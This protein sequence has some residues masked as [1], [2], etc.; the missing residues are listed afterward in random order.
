MWY[1]PRCN[2]KCAVSCIFVRNGYGD[3]LYW[4]LIIIDVTFVTDCFVEGF[5]ELSSFLFVVHIFRST[6]RNTIHVLKNRCYQLLRLHYIFYFYKLC[7]ISLNE[8]TVQTK[9]LKFIKNSKV[10]DSF[11]QKIP[12]EKMFGR[13]FILLNIIH[14]KTELPTKQNNTLGKI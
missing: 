6:N 3:Q 9:Q 13:K 2:S 7:K 11:G 14:S 1:P 5:V 8:F 10:C 4:H 12:F